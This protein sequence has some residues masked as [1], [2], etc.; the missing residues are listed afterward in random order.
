MHGDPHAREA[1][2]WN[3]TEAS[4]SDYINTKWSSFSEAKQLR[5]IVISQ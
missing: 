5:L 2:E 1:T 4:V 3:Y